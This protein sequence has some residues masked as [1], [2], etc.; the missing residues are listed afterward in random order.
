MG[1]INL[2]FRTL[3]EPLGV[4]RSEGTGVVL[5][6]SQCGQKW[7]GQ[8]GRRVDTETSGERC[9]GSTSSKVS[10]KCRKKSY[11][12]DETSVFRSR[13]RFAIVKEDLFKPVQWFKEVRI[14]GESGIPLT[15]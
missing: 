12:T 1:H 4:T 8:S 14:K 2:R 10:S 3:E 15:F 7:V 9:T 13:T 6:E 11:E 5:L